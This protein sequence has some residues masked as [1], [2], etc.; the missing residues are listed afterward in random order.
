MRTRLRPAVDDTAAFYT[1]RYPSGYDHT[2]WPDHEERVKA[3]VEFTVAALASDRGQ[4][5]VFRIADLSC[6]DGMLTISL[7][8]RL[9]TGQ[10]PFL[11]DVN[12]E[13]SRFGLDVVGSLPGTLRMMG[14]G[15]CLFVC[16]ETLEHLDDPDAFLRMLRPLT[17]YLVLT[18]PEG[19]TGHGNPEHYWGWDS[20]AVGAML[21]AA[22]FA[23]TVAHQ[24]FTPEYLT[25]DVV[26]TQM[27][28]VN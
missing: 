4:P 14:E 10:P 9:S 1:D 25:P 24:V 3:T 27:W 2:W 26:P 23:R 17:R 21:T 16:S 18:T 20:P 5:S 7:A 6:G 8:A 22:G 19:E 28:L 11:G 15:Q 12:G 13:S